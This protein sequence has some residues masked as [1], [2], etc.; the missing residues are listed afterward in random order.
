M[1]LN[2]KKQHNDVRQKAN[3]HE[4]IGNDSKKHNPY[5]LVYYRSDWS[6]SKTKRNNTNYWRFEIE[7]N[8]FKLP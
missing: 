2:I 3:K 1:K 7:H 8:G 5:R 4:T 6:E